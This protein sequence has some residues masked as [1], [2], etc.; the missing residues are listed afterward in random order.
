MSESEPEPV[1][2][3]RM[4]PV[5]PVYSLESLDSDEQNGMWRGQNNVSYKKDFE[6]DEGMV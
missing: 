6:I 2:R 4:N 5:Y 1:N 3:S